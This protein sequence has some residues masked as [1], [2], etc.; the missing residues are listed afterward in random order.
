MMKW[1]T[2]KI[3]RVSGGER[4]DRLPG[5]VSHARSTEEYP[6]TVRSVADS[7]WRTQKSRFLYTISQPFLFSFLFI[8]TL[9]CETNEIELISMIKFNMKLLF[10]WRECKT[11]EDAMRFAVNTE[12]VRERILDSTT[13][14]YAH[15]YTRAHSPVLPY[16]M[17]KLNRKLKAISTWFLNMI[18]SSFTIILYH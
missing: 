3:R 18:T 9:L 7:E 15:T 6:G 16:I 14:A 13:V 1:N 12:R 11:I 2:A 8:I 4:S 17:D 10:Y 5:K